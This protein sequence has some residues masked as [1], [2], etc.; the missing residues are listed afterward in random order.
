[1]VIKN[2]DGSVYKL[3]SPNALMKD[4]RFW[5]DYKSHN[6][7]WKLTITE[8]GS[9]VERV[10]TDFVMKDSFVEELASTAPVR[11]E[12]KPQEPPVAKTQ[13]AEDPLDGIP[14]CFIYCLPASMSQKRD[15]LYDDE[16]ISIKYGEPY[17]LE[18]VMTEEHDLCINFW[19]TADIPRESVIFPKNNQKRWWKVVGSEVS[20]GGKV[21]VCAPSTYQPHFEGT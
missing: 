19:T 14:R 16:Y 21:Y 18:G 1:M 11:D 5:T 3:R 10:Q 20:H 12:Q 7:K 15:A 6:M 13:K 2:K 4:Q 17:S 8:G 9:E